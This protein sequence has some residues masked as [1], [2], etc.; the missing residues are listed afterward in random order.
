MN[1]VILHASEASRSVEEI[2][3]A[4]EKLQQLGGIENW[5]D[6]RQHAEQL[7]QEWLELPEDTPED[8]E[9][10][11]IDS[12]AEWLWDQLDRLQ[13]IES[14]T[15]VES[16]SEVNEQQLVL[17]VDRW[18]KETMNVLKEGWQQYDRFRFRYED[19]S[20]KYEP[21]PWYELD[22][23]DSESVED[24]DG[25]LACKANWLWMEYDALLKVVPKNRF[26]EIFTIRDELEQHIDPHGSIRQGWQHIRNKHRSEQLKKQ[27]KLKEAALW[28]LPIDQLQRPRECSLTDWTNIIKPFNRT[29]FDE[30][31]TEFLAKVELARLGKV[32][33]G[34]TAEVGLK[35]HQEDAHTKIRQLLDEGASATEIQELI[36]QLP[37]GYN[38]IGL[39]KFAELCRLEIERRQDLTDALEDL[40]LRG[41]PPT[42]Y[43]A[44]YV[45][46]DWLPMFR[47]LKE[48]LKFSDEAIVMTLM[49]GVA[50]M[51]PPSLRIRGWSI[52]EIPAVWVFLIGVS[53]VAKSVLLNMLINGPMVKP[54]SAIDAWN[55][56]EMDRRRIASDAGEDVPG[57][58]KRNLIY[59]APTTQG[60][61]ADLAEQGDEV[62]GLLVR[63]EL[64]GWLKQMADDGGA[65]VGDVEFWLSSYD[66][67]YSNDVFADSRKS[68][69][70]RCGKLSVIGGIQPRVFLEQLEAGNA[71]GFNSR[72]LFVHLPRLKR[73]LIQPDEQ[74]DKLKY[75]IGD[76]YLAA[77]EETASLYLLSSEAEELFKNLFDQL[78]E[79]SLQ[80]NSEEVEALWAKGPGQVLRVSAAVHF[81]RLVTGQEE[82]VE[83]GFINKATVVSARSLQLATNLV[84]AGKTRAVQLQ[85]RAANPRLEQADRL[86]EMA[87]KRQGKFA[88]QGVSLATLRKGWPHRSRPTLEELK[89][90]ATM[91]QSRGLVLLLDGG[92]A[93]RVVR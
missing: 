15:P 69:Q 61:R 43:L 17:D 53:G 82:L 89:Q 21:K 44:D 72:P 38:Q 60:I 8:D 42:I 2:F 9:L 33:C 73:E 68:R 32:P 70:I 90:I 54:I 35:L 19:D 87:R 24:D 40:L 55:K 47:V 77:L 12:R 48:G 20:N 67:A 41:E 57:F 1:Q 86:L 49:A 64:N 59:T 79:L 36:N 4:I 83:R 84:M 27:G 50:S 93:I 81:M 56:R 58:R 91:L 30:P 76:L 22:G 92:K 51:L 7:L 14:K 13:E 18:V 46:A 65:S 63:D 80:A 88:K 5:I 45:P 75:R 62:P 52:V 10:P 39:A 26:F 6:Q 3:A 71:N 16:E 34:T 74:T 37:K 25:D 85:Q 23:G 78:E 29:E 28:L 31:F 66:G 11:A